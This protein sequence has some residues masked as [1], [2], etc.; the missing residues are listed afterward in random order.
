MAC[1]SRSIVEMSS[2]YAKYADE[3][4]VPPTARSNSKFGCTSPALSTNW[5]QA[6]MGQAP[7]P[8]SKRPHMNPLQ[9]D[10][11]TTDVFRTFVTDGGIPRHKHEAAQSMQ[12]FF[13]GNTQNLEGHIRKLRDF[14]TQL[15]QQ[16]KIAM[17]SAHTNG[18][19]NNRAVFEQ[20]V[21]LTSVHPKQFQNLLQAQYGIGLSDEET[22]ALFAR[23]GNKNQGTIDLEQFVQR[24]IRNE[25]SVGSWGGVQKTEFEMHP[26]TS[27]SLAEKLPNSVHRRGGCVPVQSAMCEQDSSKLRF[28]D[29][30]I[31]DFEGTMSNVLPLGS[32]AL[33]PSLCRRKNSQRVRR[34]IQKSQLGVKDKYND[35]ALVRGYADSWVPPCGEG[36]WD[37]S[38]TWE[39]SNDRV[40][41]FE[42]RTELA[43]TDAAT[44]WQLF[45]VLRRL[46]GTAFNGQRRSTRQPR[47][48]RPGR[49]S[50]HRHKQ[51]DGPDGDDRIK[52]QA[53]TSTSR[54][55]QEE[56]VHSHP[57]RAAANQPHQ[58]STIQELR[59]QY[60]PAH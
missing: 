59:H 10:S 4:S 60:Q 18:A 25:A 47:C 29:K 22:E 40:S 31:H 2:W 19:D 41:Q 36:A 8:P 38:P 55:K 5:E 23:Y 24:M 21:Q 32:T 51:C 39:G 13:A 56:L 17:R 54:S 57:E 6:T 7:S 30:A 15:E 26:G 20:F 14:L 11:R 1:S 16:I 43:D 34:N 42:G 33:C 49:H 3:Q 37:A 46:P 53:Q 28:A 9:C 27:P 48:A 45:G 44:D 58:Y 35:S 50:A 52:T 12:N